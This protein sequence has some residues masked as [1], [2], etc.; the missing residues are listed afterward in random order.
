MRFSRAN[1]TRDG[2]KTEIIISYKLFKDR[3]LG[4]KNIAKPQQFNGIQVYPKNIPL[5]N[6]CIFFFSTGPTSL[7]KDICNQNFN[8]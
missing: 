6:L 1:Y 8:I 5:N 4:C 2:K 3:L 7:T